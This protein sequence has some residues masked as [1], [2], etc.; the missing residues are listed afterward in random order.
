MNVKRNRTILIVIS[1]LFASLVSL[2]YFPFLAAPISSSAIIMIV[3]SFVA[4]IHQR[5]KDAIQGKATSEAEKTTMS[6]EFNPPVIAY[7]NIEGQI[8]DA[9]NTEPPDIEE[10]NH[11]V[12][13]KQYCVP[14][15]D[16]FD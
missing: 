5:K 14:P 4:L 12:I 11:K 9:Y 1:I 7:S 6:V 3:V 8:I 2:D 13:K 16:L 15:I 10:Q